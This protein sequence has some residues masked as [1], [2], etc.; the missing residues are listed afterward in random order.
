MLEPLH[1]EFDSDK[2]MT[3]KFRLSDFKGTIGLAIGEPE[4]R[5]LSIACFAFN[6]LQAMFTTYCCC[7][8]S[9]SGSQPGGSRSIVSP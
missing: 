2:D 6:G 1:K 7:L 5:N 4:M 8:S 9:A 3:R